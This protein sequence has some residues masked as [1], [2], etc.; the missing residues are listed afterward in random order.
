MKYTLIANPEK[1]VGCRICELVCSLH[2]ENVVN[3]TMSRVRVIKDDRKGLDIPITCAQCETAFC[4]KICPVGA[5]K[6][7]EKTGAMLVDGESCIGCRACL[8][9]CP[10]GAPSLH[11]TK[12]T[13]MICDLCGGEPRCARFCQ[14]KALEYVRTDRL[15]LVKKRENVARL[16]QM[17]SLIQ[18]GAPP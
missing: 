1:C 17:L 6:R 4:M 5:I 7:D 8:I 13:M 15:G 3:P 10:F 11:P 14:P 16:Q 12:R 9:A 2:H 18:S